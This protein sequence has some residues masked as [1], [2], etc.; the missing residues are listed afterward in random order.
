MNNPLASQTK[1]P[2]A[3]KEPVFL[4]DE[5][6]V[7]VEAIKD[8][9][10][11]PEEEFVLI[12]PAGAGKTFVLQYALKNEV[13]ETTF[14]CAVSH[15]A[16]QVLQESLG[17]GIK[18]MT[19]ATLL[20][21]KPVTDKNGRQTF[22]EDKYA[23]KH[24]H[25]ASRVIVDEA[26]MVDDEARNIIFLS[27]PSDCKIIYVGD[28]RQL[29]PVGNNGS[30]SSIFKLMCRAELTQSQRFSGPIGEVA[31]FY[32]AYIDYVKASGNNAD[33][34]NLLQY[35]PVMEDSNSRVVFTKNKTMFMDAAE[36]FF[37]KYP[38]EVRILAFRNIILD[39]V[40]EDMRA[41][42]VPG[43]D[44][45]TPGERIILNA[46]Y[47][48]DHNTLYNGEV[49][50]VFEV[51]KAKMTISVKQAQPNG[52]HMVDD[53]KLSFDIYELEVMGSAQ[54]KRL[55]V[56]MLH[57]DSLAM[58]NVTMQ[59]LRGMALTNKSMWSHFYAFKER[60]IDFSYLYAQSS[61]KAQGMSIDH[62]FV[63]ADD[64][65]AVKTDWLTRLK[66]LYVAATRAR[67]SLYVLID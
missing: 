15:S 9:L 53:K 56:T 66:S 3:K 23:T 57:P 13:R 35:A 8:F 52:S 39:Q 51:R 44:S 58:F 2:K 38:K 60:F 65:L 40:N 30:D 59:N 14:G 11:G 5:Q 19:L 41:I 62:V 7:A 61:H 12:G 25:V 49:L 6:K 55:Q 47:K 16:K 37:Q 17:L 27:A 64:I 21:M 18:C 46:P 48:V 54:K 28:D 29:P 50:E 34:T 31:S 67:K 22:Q 1:V 32:R 10:E 33:M 43:P 4:T 20:G 42:F 63:M 24:I 45:I 36:V 26:S